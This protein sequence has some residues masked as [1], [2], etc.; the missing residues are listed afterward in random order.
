MK[1]LEKDMED[2]II[3]NPQKYLNEIGLKLISRQYTI[4]NY[5]FDLLFED[6]HH[7]KLIV[8]IQRG[9]LDR[10]HTYKILDYFDEYKTSN[11][12]NFV[13]LMIVANKITRERR[14]RLK[15]YGITFF[16]I[17]EAVFL[18][19]PNWIS[20]SKMPKTVDYELA[21]MNFKRKKERLPSVNES[22]IL[23]KI[24]SIFS[25]KSNGIYKRKEIIDMVVEKFPETNP[26]SVIPSD[27]CYNIINKDSN[28]FTTHLFEFLGAG[29]YKCLGEK[30]PYKGE[31]FWKGQKVG[32][33]A[34]GKP[35]LKDD[36]RK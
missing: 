3:E 12:C 15:S 6:R 22:T 8:E 29:N 34:N 24:K 11:P 13:D 1:L 23:G 21:T 2:L 18:E 33:W 5:R 20:K 7:G 10:N 28:S 19:D 17:S 32:A 25:Y 14:E 16:E 27:Y 35:I 31:I 26:T 4:G 9:T 36:P 30:F